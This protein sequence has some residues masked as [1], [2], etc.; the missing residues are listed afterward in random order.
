MIITHFPLLYPQ[1]VHKKYFE[2]KKLIDP[3]IALLIVKTPLP[4]PVLCSM[5]YTLDQ[6]FRKFI[7]I[8]IGI[9]LL[10]YF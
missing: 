6:S 8:S 3:Y 9:L 1:F 2:I 10:K 5:F 7:V 4:C